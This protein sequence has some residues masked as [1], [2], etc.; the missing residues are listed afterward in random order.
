MYRYNTIF[1][2]IIHV[3]SQVFRFIHCA[4]LSKKNCFSISFWF[5]ANL[6]VLAGF[7]S[8]FL[9]FWQNCIM[10]EVTT[11]SSRHWYESWHDLENCRLMLVTTLSSTK[12]KSHTSHIQAPTLSF[13]DFQ[14]FNSTLICTQSVWN[15]TSLG[16][17]FICCQRNSS[18]NLVLN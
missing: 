6:T 8:L 13:G 1:R 4:Q 15:V 7:Y 3:I 5:A 14:N 10:I 2:V 9:L 12:W 17:I 18:I 16:W 11:T